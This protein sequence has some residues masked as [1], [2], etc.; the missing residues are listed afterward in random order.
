MIDAITGVV[1]DLS[2]AADMWLYRASDFEGRSV[3]VEM[4][5]T[6]AN[7]AGNLK[8]IVVYGKY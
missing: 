1:V 4:R 7:G 5:K 8:G 2:S 3:K 6:S